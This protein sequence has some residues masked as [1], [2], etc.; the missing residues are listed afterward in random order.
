VGEAIKNGVM[1]DGAALEPAA[2]DRARLVPG[3]DMSTL[4]HREER[5]PRERLT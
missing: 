1:I 4:Q 2:K 5:V 3:G